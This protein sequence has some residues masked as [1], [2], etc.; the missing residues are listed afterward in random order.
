MT[1]L[2]NFCAAER[3]EIVSRCRHAA[4]EGCLACQQWGNI[5]LKIDSRTAVKF[6]PGVSKDEAENQAAISTM[7]NQEIVRVPKVYDWFQDA[8]GWGY[9][10]ME[11]MTGERAGHLDEDKY[12][13]KLLRVIEH[14]HSLTAAK[15]G[16]L[17]QGPHR[18]IIFGENSSPV[19][20]STKDVEAW[21]TRRLGKD[22]G[23]V[24]FS[25]F[26]LVL[27]HLDLT[28]RNMLWIE[29][30]PP[31]LLDWACAGFY[32]R[33]FEKLS[34]DII[35]QPEDGTAIVEMH[36]SNSESEQYWLTATAF[37]NEMRYC[38]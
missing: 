23:I 36:L 14:L 8:E 22:N 4:P 3:H 25:H 11:F 24:D 6:G 12:K 9:L 20:P 33:F 35:G 30:Q 16:P 32:P 2:D 5:V 15:I 38:L 17:H 34:L 28:C 19:L 7:V 37:A 31:C 27:C 1:F 26:D 18:A 13:T 21:F 10:V 29:G